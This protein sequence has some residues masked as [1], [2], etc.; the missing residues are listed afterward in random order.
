MSVKSI[1]TKL[2]LFLLP[3]VIVVLSVLTGVSYYL[4]KQSL[5]KSVDQTAI[6]VGTDYSNRVQADMELMLSRLQ[7]LSNLEEIRTGSDKVRMVQAMAEA[8]ERFGTFDAVVFVAPDG[9]GLT[10]TGATSSYGDR[11]YFKKVI[12]TKQAVVSDP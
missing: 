11:D 3:L 10:S 2:L 1:Q 6:A 12:D 4:S 5:T 9:S 8:K 7:D